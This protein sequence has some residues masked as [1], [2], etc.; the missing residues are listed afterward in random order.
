[1]SP[2]KNRIV[3]FTIA[4]VSIT[5]PLFLVTGYTSLYWAWE[6]ANLQ[7]AAPFLPWARNFGMLTMD[8]SAVALGIL[9]SSK[10][11]PVPPRIRLWLSLLATV[12]IVFFAEFRNDGKFYFKNQ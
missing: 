6:R 2:W 7:S 3:A 12:T 4:L 5:F 8:G 9:F 10:T 11:F 1:M